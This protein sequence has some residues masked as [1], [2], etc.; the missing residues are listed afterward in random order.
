[1]ELPIALQLREFGWALLFGAG[2]GLMQDLL[3]PLRRGRVST[4]LTDSLYCLLLLLGLLLFALYAGRGRL[5]IFA[6]AAMALSGGLW[7][8]LISPG[9]RRLELTRRKQFQKAGQSL[10][11]T[12][13]RM[14]IFSKNQKN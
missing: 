10:Q 2:A 14:K 9:F 6:L 4:A 8:R 13:K 12:I 5:R 3:R 11:K 1:M 7:L